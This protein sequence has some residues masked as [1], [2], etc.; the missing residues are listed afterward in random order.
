MK[1]KYS[2]EYNWNS[3]NTEYGNT[4]LHQ[5]SNNGKNENSKRLKQLTVI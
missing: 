1:M 5:A 4:T 3:C 2:H